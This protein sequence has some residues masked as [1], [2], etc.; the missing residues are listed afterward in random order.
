MT[1]KQQGQAAGLF[2]A[3]ALFSALFC[4]LFIAGR[5]RCPRRTDH[6]HDLAFGRRAGVTLSELG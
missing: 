6:N 4:W 2:G 1:I 5:F 3:V